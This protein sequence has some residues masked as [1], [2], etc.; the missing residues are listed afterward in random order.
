[1][2][3]IKKYLSNLVEL[4]DDYWKLFSSK[5]IKREFPKKS[6]ILKMNDVEKYLSFVEKGIIRYY[7][8][9]DETEITVNF[10]FENEFTS[11]YASFLIQS[12]SIYT[13]EV[14]SDTILWSIK[15]NDIQEIY[16]SSFI[17]NLLG[18]ISA[19]QL[20]INKAK[21][22]I[23]LLKNSAEERYLNLLHQQ[24]NL[25]QHI[26]LKYLAS[27]IGVTPQ[28]LSRIRKRIS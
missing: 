27:Y 5:L 7:L 10:S 8:I 12:P 19:E 4:T 17:G 9:R 22:E 2:E 20:F 6:I 1:V 23:S 21:R 13:T 11:S 18:R 14:L 3:K 26:P 28:A 25:I 16:N 15:Y 24:P